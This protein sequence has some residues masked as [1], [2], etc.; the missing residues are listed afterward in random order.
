MYKAIDKHLNLVLGIWGGA[1]GLAYLCAL[2]KHDVESAA[3]K[4]WLIV[5]ALCFL[6]VFALIALVLILKAKAEARKTFE[7]YREWQLTPSKP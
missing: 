4:H 2:A 6:A 1:G 7:K 3:L 5:A